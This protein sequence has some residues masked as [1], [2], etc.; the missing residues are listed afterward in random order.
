MNGV[1]APGSLTIPDAMSLAKL[2]LWLHGYWLSWDRERKARV[3]PA[4][5]PVAGMVA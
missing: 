1:G 4:G 5:A 2:T 3:G